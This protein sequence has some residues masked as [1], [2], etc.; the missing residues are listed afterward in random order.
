MFKIVDKKLLRVEPNKPADFLHPPLLYHALEKDA[1]HWKLS[2]TTWRETVA[3]THWTSWCAFPTQYD[4]C[5]DQSFLFS[6]DGGVRNGLAFSVRPHLILCQWCTWN[7]LLGMLSCTSSSLVLRGDVW[8]WLARNLFLLGASSLIC[9]CRDDGFILVS[10]A[11]G[12]NWRDD[13]SPAWLREI[14][15]IL[16]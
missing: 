12:S 5:S 14:N 6:L 3:S 7:N 15:V 10:L 11:S 16:I 9:L 2:F 8:K 4:S 1:I 13:A